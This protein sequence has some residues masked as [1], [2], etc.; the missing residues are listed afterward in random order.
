[1]SEVEDLEKREG[2][3]RGWTIQDSQRNKKKKVGFQDTINEVINIEIDRSEKDEHNNNN[4]NN[5][6]NKII[7][8]TTTRKIGSRMRRWLMICQDY[9]KRVELAY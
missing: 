3:D 2:V 5:N 6:T 8:I 1:M 9:K 4:N 7:M